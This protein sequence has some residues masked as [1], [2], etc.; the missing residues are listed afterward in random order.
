MKILAVGDSFVPTN[1]FRRGLAGLE[2]S[3]E[4][5]YLDL[6]M[7]AQFEPAT[8]SE[9]GIREHAGNPRQ[10]VAAL[11]DEEVLLVHG[12]P[13]TD[14]VLDASP[15]L[16]IVGVA[17]GG[18]VNIDVEAATRRGITVISAPGRNADAVA[19]LTLALII[20]L[21]R[22]I[23]R[24]VDFLKSGGKL[25]ESAFEG[26]QFFGSELGGHTLGLV[27]YGNVGARVAE[28]ALVFGMSVLVYDPY[29]EAATIERPGIQVTGLD[30]L[31]AR[32]DY[33]SLHA[34]ATPESINLF[35]AKRFD[36]MKPGA[37]FINSARETL[38]DEDALYDALT[39]GG[40]AGAALDV[41]RPR[42]DGS[43]PPLLTL[44]NVII[45]PH[46]GGATYEA[47]LLGVEI[48]AA[49]LQNCLRGEKM[50]HA[51][52]RVSVGQSR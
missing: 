27:G 34:R 17:R 31:L 30:D 45:T 29:V 19:D 21:G 1:L 41:M 38:L 12:A 20:M 7:E 50:A 25:G 11:G 49:Q 32:S 18:P 3:N 51:V 28:R 10:L 44:D 14:E 36:Q 5:R 37:F 15:N 9:R 33:V 24:S 40:L 4:I 39:T 52:N 42:P 23:P 13:V 47:A 2:A 43:A 26:A 16:K 35:D 48:L 6:D 8:T 46:I 22:G